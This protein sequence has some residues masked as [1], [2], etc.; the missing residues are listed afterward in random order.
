MF[1]STLEITSSAPLAF[2]GLAAA[3]LALGAG[4][5]LEHGFD[6]GSTTF[7]NVRESGQKT[8]ATPA[9]P[10]KPA[11]ASAPATYGRSARLPGPFAAR[12]TRVVDGDTFEA[13]IPIWFGQEKTVL[14][15][16]RGMDAP[17]L[18]ARCP[19]ERQLAL[20]ARLVLMEVLSAGRV[21]LHEVTRDK[22]AGRIVADIRVNAPIALKSEDVPT[23]SSIMI[24]SG[25]ARP[26]N[27]GKRLSWCRSG[28]YLNN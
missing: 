16:L 19:A 18:K 27:K 14:V 1:H 15:R 20:E 10:A 24:A 4:A 21:S 25:Y 17:E 8:I 28:K 26:Y 22:Y 13:Q 5:M 6:A 11:S 9:S 23:V 12:V 2:A 7:N 3:A